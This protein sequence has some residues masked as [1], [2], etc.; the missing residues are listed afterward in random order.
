MSTN[1]ENLNNLGGLRHKGIQEAIDS[2]DLTTGVDHRDG[3]RVATLTAGAA[4]S[5][6]CA[7]GTHIVLMVTEFRMTGKEKGQNF[8]RGGFRAPSPGA[9]ASRM[10]YA[11]G[12]IY[13]EPG[14]VVRSPA[15]SVSVARGQRSEG[16]EDGLGEWGRGA[17]PRV[18]GRGPGAGA[19]AGATDSGAWRR[20]PG[21]WRLAPGAWRR[22]PGAW[23]LAL[24][25]GA[26]RGRRAGA[27]VG[28]CKWELKKEFTNETIVEN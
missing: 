8:S 3:A 4:A 11:F 15:S 1:G 12:Y 23:R 21:A 26:E 6:V 20:A 10:L 7:H 9:V 19:E 14:A 25:A 16:G 2:A 27:C 24:G 28:R 17:G 22:A 18:P 5:A 13:W